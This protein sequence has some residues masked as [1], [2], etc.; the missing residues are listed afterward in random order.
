MITEQSVRLAKLV[1]WQL[2]GF[3]VVESIA[4]ILMAINAM[5]KFLTV[6]VVNTGIIEVNTGFILVVALIVLLTS[7]LEIAILVEVAN[8][9][10]IKEI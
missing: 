7:A 9:L 4:A 2:I 10:E 5:P 8:L 1:A 3:L 6:K